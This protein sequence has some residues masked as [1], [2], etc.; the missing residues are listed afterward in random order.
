MIKG[1]LLPDGPG[2]FKRL[3]DASCCFSFNGVHDLRQAA[4]PAIISP[5]WRQNQVHMVGHD[6]SRMQITRT[7]V[8]CQA[9]LQNNIPGCRGKFPAV[10]GGKSDEHRPA[11]FLNVGK[12]A[13]V[14]ISW[15][16]NM[17]SCGTA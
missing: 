16:H 6:N 8:F 11:V 3:I 10:V 13:A 4:K 9:T 7:T 14:C 1:F 5:Q 2:A 15:L 12:P 17:A